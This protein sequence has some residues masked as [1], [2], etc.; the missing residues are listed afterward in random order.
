MIGEIERGLG[1]ALLARQTGGVAG[2]GS[3][4]TAEGHL[5]LERFESFAQDVGAMLEALF[6]KHF[7]DLPLGPGTVA[8]HTSRRQADF[9]EC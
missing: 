1:V 6:H 9:E 4:L 2:G 5:V 8:G 7:G 3:H